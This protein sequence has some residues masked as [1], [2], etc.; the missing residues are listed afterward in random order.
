MKKKTPT[1]KVKELTKDEIIQIYKEELKRKDDLILK[2][3]NENKLLLDLTL[4][5]TKKRLEELDEKI[6]D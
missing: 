2:L 1:P 5:N 6:K 4:K 3:E